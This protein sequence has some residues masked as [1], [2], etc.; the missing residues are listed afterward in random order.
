MSER[1]IERRF[2]AVSA[3]TARLMGVDFIP[4]GR[5]GAADAPAAT[6][7]I[8]AKPQIGDAPGKTTEPDA[9]RGNSRGRD[10]ERSVKLLDELRARYEADAPHQH[11][12][13]DHHSIVFGEGD[14][15][16][17]LMFIGE[18]P[19]AEED[20]TGR[21]FVGKAGQ[22][23]DKMIVAMGL[24]RDDV[25]ICNVLKTRPPGNATPTGREAELCKPYLID[26]V[27]IVN[28]EVIVTLGL[29][30]SKTV[31][32]TEA[33]MGSLRGKFAKVRFLAGQGLLP[34]A[35]ELH[36]GGLEIPVMPTY[37]PAY[38]LRDY[39]P[40]NRKKVWSDLLQVVKFL[41]LTPRAAGA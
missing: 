3:D 31:L 24:K 7:E 9:V 15:C 37:H 6:V 30:A 1:T 16:A 26:Q 11:F 14:P 12:V 29:P 13:T 38:L 22:L 4:L 10:R 33:S 35:K 39:T 5:R 32:A 2:V 25:Y 17:R 28:P 36:A 34:A 19:G 18:A 21:P 20:K 27:R 23:L 40:E 8:E 41:G